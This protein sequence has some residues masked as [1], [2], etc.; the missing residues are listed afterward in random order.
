VSVTDAPPPAPPAPEPA[1]GAGAPLVAVGWAATVMS[2]VMY[3]SYLD[4]ITRNLHGQ[5][6]SW[7]QPLA[8]MIACILWGSYGLFRRRIDWPLVLANAPGVV[9]GGLAA[10]TALR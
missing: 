1:R 4:Q 9:L 5:K 2:V 7:V 3:L 6:G 8:A 10:A